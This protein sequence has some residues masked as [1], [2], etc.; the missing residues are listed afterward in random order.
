KAGPGQGVAGPARRQLQGVIGQGGL[1]PRLVAA[2]LDRRAQARRVAVAPADGGPGDLVKAAGKSVVD[3]VA[4]QAFVSN[5]PTLL[6]L[7]S[8]T[9]PASSPFSIRSARARRMRASS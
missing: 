4:H 6:P 7:T 8:R 9:D 1:T 5:W 3:G 2:A